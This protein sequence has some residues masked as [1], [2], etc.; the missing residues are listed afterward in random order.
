MLIDFWISF[1]D[2]E[3]AL[4]L[5]FAEGAKAFGHKT[6]IRYIGTVPTGRRASL[7]CMIGVKSR[8]LFDG[9]LA[10]GQRVLYFDKGYSRHRG[11]NGVWEYWRLSL[12]AHQPTSTTLMRHSYPADRLAGLG[13]D[14]REWRHHG[15]HVIIAGSSEKYS[16]F[17]SLPHPTKHA[18]A[19]VKALRGLTNRRLVYRPKPSWRNAKPIPGTYFSPRIEPLTSLLGNAWCLITH[20]SNACL[21]A[22]IMG[23]PSIILGD[24]VARP[25]SSTSL[26][27]IEYPRLGNR[28]QWLQNLAYHQ[29]TEAE[30]REGRAWPTIQGWLDAD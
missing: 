25:I 28:E 14:P 18:A 10:S 24:A 20:G 27:E 16:Q 22:A 4:A 15:D 23:V 5:A 17:Y 19:M 8:I 2:R 6:R 12:D 29:W 11:R 26:T 9:C 1:K 21:E 13:F 7:A 3:M 30:M